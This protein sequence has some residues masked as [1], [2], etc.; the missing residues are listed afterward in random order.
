M[1]TAILGLTNDYVGGGVLPH[2][3]VIALADNL[4]WVA[5][6]YLEKSLAGGTDPYTFT[7]SEYE[8]SFIKL[9]GALTA[10]RTD[11]RLPAH[12]GRRWFFW[13]ATTGGFSTTLKTASGSGIAL[14]MNEAGWLGSDGTNI[15]RCGPSLDM[16][17]LTIP[18]A[19]IPLITSAKRSDARSSKTANYAATSADEWIFVDTTAG[20]V[21]ITLPAANACPHPIGV[22]KTVAA[23]TLTVQRAGSDTID[24]ATTKAWTTQ[25]ESYIFVPDGASLWGIF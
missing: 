13:N 25:Y 6:G 4:E 17:A 18:L 16:S 7:E 24:G 15:V 2:A 21:T 22:K 10:N 8:K 23:N 12:A 1:S 3:D 14:A 11:Q 19:L 20:S 5:A 9:T